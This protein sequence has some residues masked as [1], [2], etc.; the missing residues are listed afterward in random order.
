[1]NIKKIF[2]NFLNKKINKMNLNDGIAYFTSRF[3]YT[4]NSYATTKKIIQWR[5]NVS[6]DIFP[7][8]LFIEIWKRKRESDF[9][10]ATKCKNLVDHW[11]KRFIPQISYKLDCC[12]SVVFTVQNNNKKVIWGA[13]E[14][15]NL[16]V[17][18]IIVLPFTFYHLKDIIINNEKYTCDICLQIIGK[19]EILEEKIKMGKSIKYNNEEDIMEDV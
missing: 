19:N 10:I 15:I 7:L 6:R 5:W 1:M 14:I 3:I 2:F 12:F 9:N 13:I 18:E 4:L 11:A 8:F 16:N 17:E